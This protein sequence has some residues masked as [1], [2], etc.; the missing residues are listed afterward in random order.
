MQFLKNLILYVVL[1]IALHMA[2]E[3]D[4]MSLYAIFQE[5]QEFQQPVASIIQDKRVL[6][7]VVPLTLTYFLVRMI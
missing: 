4:Y 6:W 2:N 7:Q 1:D 3:H 5:W